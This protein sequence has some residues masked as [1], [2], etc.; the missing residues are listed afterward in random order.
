M[1]EGYTTKNLMRIGLTYLATFL[2]SLHLAL[3][4]DEVN[5]GLS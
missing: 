3:I 1:K 4:N 5:N 2:T